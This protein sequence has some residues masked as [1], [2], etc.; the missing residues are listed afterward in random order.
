[1]W[2]WC[3]WARGAWDHFKLKC[4]HVRTSSLTQMQFN[5]P[6]FI[7][8]REAIHRA[9]AHARLY[10]DTFEDVSGPEK[11]VADR[12]DGAVGHRLQQGL[13]SGVVAK[14]K[15]AHREMTRQLYVDAYC[16]QLAHGEPHIL[17]A[18]SNPN[19]SCSEPTA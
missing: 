5:R 9:R 11:T 16:R 10:R 18:A 8:A 3:G 13:D 4:G 19:T 14:T 1:M 2:A 15:A 12:A 6:S 17:W 7:L